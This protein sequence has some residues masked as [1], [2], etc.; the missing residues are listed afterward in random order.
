MLL[1]NS[2]AKHLKMQNKILF[3]CLSCFFIDSY[4]F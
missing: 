1:N 2:G 4:D 3:K